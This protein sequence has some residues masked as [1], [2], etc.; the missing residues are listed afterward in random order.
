MNELLEKCITHFNYIKVCILSKLFPNKYIVIKACVQ[1][2]NGKIVNYNWGDDLNL[3]LIK[4]LTGKKILVLP[5]CSFSYKFPI[6]SYSVIGSIIT[7][8]P[9]KKTI[10]WG[11]GIINSNQTKKI[12]SAPQAI[13]S[14]RGPRTRSEL[15]RIGIDCPQNY[16][17]PALL[18]P[19]F[20]KPITEKKYKIGVIP[21]YIDINNKYV[22]EL[23]KNCSVKLIK[24]Q[25][26]RDW[27][28]FINDICSCDLVISS[29][30]HGL[31]ISEAYKIPCV[32]AEFGEYEDDWE[33]KFLDFFE[34]IN[35]FNEHPFIFDK[36]YS[37]DDLYLLCENWK[38]GTINTD[39][40][41][42]TCPFY[43]KGLDRN[44]FE[45][46]SKKIL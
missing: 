3:I 18:M 40:I 16:G 35:K 22:Q 25:G 19:M 1:Y 14:V 9:L 46:S 34:S 13:T 21:H 26:Y 32:W 24:V 28:D 15:L 20:Y 36:E 45:K 44:E 2:K 4:Y 29:S 33:F 5:H 8:F 42:E 41:L 37:L 11:S 10:I 17:D 43:D 39:I 23:I 31:I 7:F 12:H 30:L 6:K 38:P 27:R